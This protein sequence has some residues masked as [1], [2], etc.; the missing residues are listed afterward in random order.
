M[1]NLYTA[2][3]CMQDLDSAEVEPFL[4]RG[5]EQEVMGGAIVP[6]HETDSG[7]VIVSTGQGG[8]NALAKRVAL[9]NCHAPS[10]KQC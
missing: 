7:L 10:L 8:I 9:A 1:D 4:N 6:D 5:D 3:E 2:T